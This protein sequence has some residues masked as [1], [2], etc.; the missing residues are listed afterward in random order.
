MFYNQTESTITQQTVD[1]VVFYSDCRYFSYL[2]RLYLLC[3]KS[4]PQNQ[5]SCMI[6]FIPASSKINYQ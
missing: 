4:S 1:I 2:F 6:Y 3:F 5:P